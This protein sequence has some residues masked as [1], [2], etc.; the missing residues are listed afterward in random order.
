MARSATPLPLGWRTKAGGADNAEASDFVLEVVRHVVRAMV[1]ALGQ[2]FGPTPPK[3]RVIPWRTGSGACQ[4][5]APDEA[6][7]PMNSPEH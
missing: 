2:T 7:V 1:V 6:C 3:W 5:L 4:R